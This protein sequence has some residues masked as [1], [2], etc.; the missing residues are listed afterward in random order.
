M[1]GPAPPPGPAGSDSR[2]APAADGAGRAGLPSAGAGPGVDPIQLSHAGTRYV[3][4]WGEGFFGI[5][6]RTRP[7]PPVERFPRTDDG[8]SQAWLRYRSLEPNAVE[9]GATGGAAGGV[10]PPATGPLPA[11]PRRVNA[12]WWLL[13]ILVGWLGGLIA[14]LVNRD[15]DRRVARNMLITGIVV[16]VIAIVIITT[17]TPRG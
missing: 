6:D 17:S 7:G 15:V 2:T 11:V 9:V 8:W 14:W 10:P 12:A 5:W 1:L 13:P 16:S 4:G 3:L